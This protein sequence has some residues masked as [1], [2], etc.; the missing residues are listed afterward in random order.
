MTKVF[1]SIVLCFFISGCRLNRITEVIHISSIGIESYGDGYNCYFY[2]PHSANINGEDVNEG[3]YMK[4]NGKSV[5]ECFEKRSILNEF[6]VN[7]R[8]V[9][10]IIFHKNVMNDVFFDEFIMFIKNGYFLDFNFYVFVTANDL[11]DVFSFKTPN[12]ESVLNSILVSTGDSAY[13]FLAIN[14]LHFLCFVRDYSLNKW[15][16]IPVI[17]MNEIWNYDHKNYSCYSVCYYS[18]NNLLIN[19]TE[20]CYFFKNNANFIVNIDGVDVNFLDYKIDINYKKKKIVVKSKYT[21]LNKDISLD[22]VK[23]LIKERIKRYLIN[24][25][26]D[27]LNVD[28]YNQ[29][30]TLNYKINDY[31]IDVYINY[32]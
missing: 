9:S 14:P 22:R 18:N 15:V 26:V 2:A 28:Y 8:H 17:D 20:D 25:N 11:S 24:I 29:L 13:E 23:S 21:P 31:E 12:D 5:I 3:Q 1:L 10:C 30:Y 32:V 27:F 7:L 6:E 16:W 4:I 19:R